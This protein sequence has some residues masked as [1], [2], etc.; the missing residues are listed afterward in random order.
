MKKQI[1]EST[2]EQTKIDRLTAR[3]QEIKNGREDKYTLKTP[4]SK[5]RTPKNGGYD[6]SF[7]L[8]KNT[9]KSYFQPYSK[10]P[11]SK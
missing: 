10:E 6:A 7:P 8:K 9:S 4:S 2:Q 3:E 11:F 5:S 1:S